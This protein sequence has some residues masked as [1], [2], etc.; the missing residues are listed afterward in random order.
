MMLQ[1]QQND[2]IYMNNDGSMPVDQQPQYQQMD[3]YER[4]NQDQDYDEGEEQEDDEMQGQLGQY[5]AQQDDEEEQQ[6]PEIVGEE[7]EMEEE[8]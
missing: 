6:E 3:H 2:Q 8:E 5:M 7:M 1:Q 4:V